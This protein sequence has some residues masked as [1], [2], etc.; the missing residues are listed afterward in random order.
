M[1]FWSTSVAAAAV[2]A[3]LAAC[4]ASVTPSGAPGAVTTQG[5]PAGAQASANPGAGAPA[6]SAKVVRDVRVSPENFVVS[7][8]DA[9]DLIAVVTYTDG[10]SDAN[11]TWSSSD[12]RIVDINPTTGKIQAKGEGV[13]TI[14][15]AALGDN[16][17][18]ANVQVTVRKGSVTEA[19]AKVEPKEAA[20][21]VGET[22]QLAAQIQLS[23]GSNSPNVLYTSSNQ[24]VAVVSGAG[25]VTAAGKGKATITVSA[26]GD[27]TR[28]AACAVTVTE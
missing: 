20:L 12:S 26:S 7:V 16:A 28:R 5:T 11:V 18:K 10:T 1:R 22:V 21:A 9:K 27:A 19:L 6:S 14:V 13:A 17:R 25:L 8:N 2:A 23:D 15:V 4:T 24:S 3:S